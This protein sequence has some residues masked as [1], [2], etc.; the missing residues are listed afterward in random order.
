MTLRTDKDIKLK[1]FQGKKVYILAKYIDS[2]RKFK[3][4]AKKKFGL[5]KALFF[6]VT[7]IQAVVS[8]TLRLLYKIVFCLK[9]ITT[10][11]KSASLHY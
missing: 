6:W 3:I 8:K 7:L 10:L 5:K 2:K 9:N 1:K 11:K 4:K